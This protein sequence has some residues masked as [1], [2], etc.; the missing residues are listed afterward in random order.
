LFDLMHDSVYVE[1]T[2]VVFSLGISVLAAL[3]ANSLL[4]RPILSSAVLVITFLDLMLAGSGKIMN[5]SSLDAEPGIAYSQ[6]GGNH[7]LMDGIRQRLNQTSPPARFDLYNDFTGWVTTTPITQLPSANGNDPFAL[8]RLMQVRLLFSTGERWG[9]FYQVTRPDSPILDL[10]NVQVLLSMTPVPENPKFLKAAEFPGHAI[11]ESSS[12]LPRF[13]LVSDVARAEDMADAV[14]Q[15][16]A[17]AFNPAR[18]AV[19]E[20]GTAEHF[21]D[22]ASGTVRIVE[23]SPSEVRLQVE[24]AQPRYL[25]TSEANY[26]GWRAFLDGHMCPISMT[27]I[28][29]R[30]LP[31]PA[32]NHE[33]V[34]RFRPAILLWS[35]GVSILACLA[36]AW[37][38]FA[39][40]WHN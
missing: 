8:Y 18:V 22:G 9:R 38:M 25:V 39:G 28:A 35:A 36:L 17:P 24:S 30:G 19:V 27:N 29:F 11:Y 34:F 32:G 20:Q 15:L 7:E 31:V 4:R 26:P 37:L 23:Y 21:A 6:F 2:M 10:L 12:A 40:L 13:F 16:G 3:G 33:V 14:R 5:A 1:F